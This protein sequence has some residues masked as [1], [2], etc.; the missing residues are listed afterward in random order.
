METP[1]RTV[2][3]LFT[4][5]QVVE[6]LAQHTALAHGLPP[7]NANLATNFSFQ[8]NDQGEPRLKHVR[9]EITLDKWCPEE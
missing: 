9:V 1:L 6:I 7:G 3:M 2:R 8:S 5:D 4:V